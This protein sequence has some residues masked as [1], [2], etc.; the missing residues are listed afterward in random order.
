MVNWVP[1]TSVRSVKPQF[2]G[3]LSTNDVRTGG[4]EVEKPKF[5]NEIFQ[6]QIN[7][8][9]FMTRPAK[10][11]SV[12]F[13]DCHMPTI[14]IIAR[15]LRGTSK[16]FR[17]PVY[18]HFWLPKTP[19]TVRF[20][21]RIHE[22]ETEFQADHGRQTTVWRNNYRWVLMVIITL[23]DHLVRWVKN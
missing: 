11:V 17:V 18:G 20:R 9:S 4:A 6:L 16:I 8:A 14:I 1:S 12:S 2:L 23:R 5:T 19:G 10:V 3:E 7:Y 15:L 21:H 13:S 22:C